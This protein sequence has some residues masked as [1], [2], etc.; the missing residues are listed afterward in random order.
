MG[1]FIACFRSSNDVK[2]RKQRRRKVLP[3]DQVI[4][5]SSFLKLISDLFDF[6]QRGCRISRVLG[7]CMLIRSVL[8]SIM[9]VFAD[10][11]MNLL[12]FL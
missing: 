3:R 4:L 10:S 8:T 9:L 1:C 2:R 5:S 11:S 6:I 7:F 12:D